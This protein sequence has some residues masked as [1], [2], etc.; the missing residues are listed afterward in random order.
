MEEWRDIEGYEGLY[1]ISNKGRVKSL[2]YRMTRKE[3]ILKPNDTQGYL[4]IR[5][6]KNKNHKHYY[7][8]RLVADAFIPNSNNLPEVNHKD[9]DKHNNCVDNLEWCTS[10]YNANYG[11]RNVRC[12]SKGDK[13][14]RAKKV[15]CFELDKEYACIRYAADDLN[16][17]TSSISDC[18]RHYKGRKVINGYHFYFSDNILSKGVVK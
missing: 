11:T 17:S 1:Q 7:V 4:Q 18:C 12:G 6:C 10:Q 9:E 13:H 8:H 3:G 2:N 15:Y 5:L 14:F 16:I